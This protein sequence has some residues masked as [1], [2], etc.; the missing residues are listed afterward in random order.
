MTDTADTP[1]P[2]LVTTEWVADHLDDADV[3]IIDVDEDTEAY[4]RSHL[5]GA[6]GVNWT[7]DLQDPVRRTFLDG[8]G[9]GK[10]MD[11]LGVTS[12]SH[13]VLYGGNN[14]WFAAYAYWYLALYGHDR[15]S[16]MDGGRKKWEVE[17]REMTSEVPRPTASTGYVAG[18]PDEALRARR[19]QML[20]DFVDAPSGVSLIDVRSPAEFAGETTSPA[21]LPGEAAMVPGHIPGA[22]N[23]PWSQ[24]VDP[25]TGE[26]LPAAELRNLYEAA[27]I[28]PDD[29]VI[30]YCRIGERA[31]HTWFALHE[32]LGI[33]S[34]R[35]YDGSWTEYGSLIDVPVARGAV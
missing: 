21:H 6:L 5:P 14:N 4:G 1:T 17:G 28:D 23:V 18:P 33:E 22:A 25:D 34:V 20:T 32:I 19:N 13:V 9:F 35:N 16:L 29:E 26:F 30:T 10:L 3:V 11:R 31:A 8:E 7:T 2:A 27:G 24:A 12:E 15:A